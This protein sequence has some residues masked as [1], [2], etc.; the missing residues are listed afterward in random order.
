MTKNRLEFLKIGPDPDEV[1]LRVVAGPCAQ[2]MQISPQVG[3]PYQPMI[4]A[5]AYRRTYVTNTQQRE[6]AHD[7]FLGEHP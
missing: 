5:A 3:C 2:E 7:Q 1:S 4:P 6:L